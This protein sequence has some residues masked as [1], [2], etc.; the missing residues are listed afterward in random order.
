[1]AKLIN[2]TDSIGP[3]PG[4]TWEEEAADAR[5]P[6]GGECI[7]PYRVIEQIDRGK[8][9]N[10]SCA[11]PISEKHHFCSKKCADIGRSGS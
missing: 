11:K 5:A 1:M 10:W 4:R 6:N 8:C 7:F 9:D 2:D 3:Y